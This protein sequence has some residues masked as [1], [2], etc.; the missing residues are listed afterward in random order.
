MKKLMLIACVAIGLQTHAQYFDHDYGSVN[1]EEPQRGMNTVAM[2]EGFVI[3]GLAT[4]TVTAVVGSVVSRTNAAGMNT[5]APYF[6]NGY[7]VRTS[8]GTPMNSRDARILEQGSN[9][10]GLSGA[11]VIPGSVTDFAYHL[12]LNP[13]G[14]VLN[15]TL[16]NSQGYSFYRITSVASSTTPNQQYMAG[17]AILNFTGETQIVVMKIGFGGAIVWA[18]IYDMVPGAISNET[19]YDLAENPATG[20]LVVVGQTTLSGGTND[21]FLLRLNPA[22][23]AVIGANTYGT[24]TSNET[25]TGIELS[26]DPTTNF[27]YIIS[28]YTDNTPGA[29][30][31]GWLIRIDNTLATLWSNIYDYNG[32][33]V[34]NYFYDVKE[35]RNTS[36][37]FEYYAGGTTSVG[38]TG[39]VDIEVDKTAANGASVGQFTYGTN[40]GEALVS[41]DVNNLP[42][43]PGINGLSMYG[44]RSAGLLGLS[45]LTIY[46]AYFNGITACDY[47]INTIIETPGPGL[48]STPSPNLVAHLIQ[49]P[50]TTNVSPGLD[51][52][53]CF[54]NTVAGGSNARLAQG[55][56]N[57]LPTELNVYNTDN[58]GSYQVQIGNALSGKAEI[59]VTDLMGRVVYSGTTEL[60]EG[61]NIIPV[62]LSAATEA[63]IY[64]LNTTVGGKTYSNK[65]VVVK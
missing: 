35:R 38:V 29:D 5:G 28:G 51:K 8:A 19:A 15:T 22:T 11:C 3:S 14:P 48:L 60:Q 23:G 34:N 64:M 9:S 45:D 44:Y 61:S 41:I 7:R 16:Y 57:E 40:V 49:Q 17:S 26:N 6:T 54:A 52:T 32:T 55:K 39:T 47:F 62:E 53:K 58:A 18:L 46:K 31:D 10:F 20:E 50:G 24:A 27:G 63:G 56:S 1:L 25:F 12:Q 36:G 42:S 59:Q 43:P 13:N 65:L 2:G 21:A 4:N 33:F 37:F 30:V